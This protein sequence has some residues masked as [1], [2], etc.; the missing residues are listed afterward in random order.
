VIRS[1]NQDKPYARFVKE[2]LAGDAFY[3]GTADGILGLGFIAAGPWDFVGQ[4]ELREGTIDKTITRNLDRDDMVSVTMNT[5]VSLTA[6]CARCHNHKFDPILQADYYS[7]QACF[8]GVNRGERAVEEAK[9]V[10]GRRPEFGYHSAIS[11]RQD[12]TKWV[13]VDLG[14]TMA[15]ERIVL[16]GAHDDYNNIGAGFGFPLRYKVEISGDATFKAGGVTIVDRTSADVKNPG[17]APQVIAAGGKRGR[18]VRVTAT[19]LAPRQNDYIFALGELSVMSAD[20]K[21]VA[22]G[23]T[24]AALDS[25]EAPVRWGKANLVDGYF[26]REEDQSA[27]DRAPAVV[28]AAVPVKPR[29]VY[30]LHRGSEKQPEKEMGPGTVSLSYVP[31]LASRFGDATLP[32]KERRAALAA[33]IVSEKNPLTWRSIV[34][35]VW[36]YHFGRG[37][38]ETP[39]DFGH[40]GAMPTHPELLD[41]LAVE[42]RD[43]GDFLTAQSIKSL[44]RL[45]VTSATYRQS[46]TNDDKNAAID[47][48]NQF[49][50]RMNRARLDAEEIHDSVLSVAGKLD[51][52]MGGPGYRDFGFKDDHSPHYAYGEYDPDDVTTQRRSVYRLVVRSV[53]DPFMETLDCADPSQMVA[54]RNETLTP[55]QALALLNNPFM[56]KMAEHFAARVEKSATDNEGRIDAACKLAYGRA[57]N[58]VEKK[59]LGEIERK[60]GMAS[61]CRVILNSNE[62]VFVD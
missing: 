6:Q 22:L 35:R 5:F 21:N 62:F 55:L 13:Q 56:V 14:Q 53:P 31:A 16:V 44:Q 39:N 48:G 32:E 34:N 36:Q 42:F 12:V 15:I 45:I 23:K 7:L 50:W 8:A 43:G 47:G 40:M 57:A 10:A 59:T 51:L 17:V 24:V 11:P 3:P 1:F 58:D 33:W 9:P 4:V 60:Y 20:G 37:I 54:R 27:G 25:I 61:V 30:L 19:K 41:W 49:L 26:Y 18:Y 29:P 46:C 38:V 52:K 2:Q 28:Y